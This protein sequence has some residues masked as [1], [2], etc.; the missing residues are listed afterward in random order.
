MLLN[1]SFRHVY[2]IDALDKEAQRNAKGQDGSQDHCCMVTSLPTMYDWIRS[3][4]HLLVRMSI[5]LEALE[6]GAHD[7]DEEDH[8]DCANHAR[9]HL[10]TRSL[11]C[12]HCQV[13]EKGEHQGTHDQEEAS[14]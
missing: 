12:H 5:T 9:Q 1:T 6:Y 3:N 4:S 13:A 7:A 11:E 2:N 8:E 10:S 14:Q